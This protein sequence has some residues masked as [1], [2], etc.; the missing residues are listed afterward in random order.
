MET[1]ISPTS[2]VALRLLCAGAMHPIIDALADELERIAAR[3]VSARF[4]NSG[5]VKTRVLAGEQV[6]VVITTAAAMDELAKHEKILRLGAAPLAR[7]AIGV[8]VR[9]GAA[10]P[11]IGSV[12]SF[13]RALRDARSIAIADPVTG[14]PSG[15]H[16]V[17][18]LAR[19][20]MTA[21]LAHK[22]RWVGGGAGGV[23]VVGEVVAKGEAEI[24]LQQIAEILGVPGLDLVGALPDELQHVTVF[25]AAVAATSR[26]AAAACRVVEH[27]A[28]H[29]AA[30]IIR[31]KG[32]EPA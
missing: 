14:S 28:S 30:A 31:A 10:R 32:M 7:S 4:A 20:G 24:G 6:D 12:E 11:D 15:N 5:G 16:L 13:R 2:D 26:D 27:L 17:A 29:Q 18:V 23:V 19:L 1:P 25:C 9:A 3:P 21:E 22:I 8:A